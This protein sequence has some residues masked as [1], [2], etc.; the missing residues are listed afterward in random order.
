MVA[1]SGHGTS[2]SKVEDTYFKT[3]GLLIFPDGYAKRSTLR[4]T[5]FSCVTGRAQRVYRMDYDPAGW[6]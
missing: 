5:D 6:R 2:S 3:T 1:L 4:P